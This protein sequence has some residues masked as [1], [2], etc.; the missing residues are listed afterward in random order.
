M[1]PVQM[2]QTNYL[3][4]FTSSGL[5]HTL[6]CTLTMSCYV[7]LDVL[8]NQCTPFVR[9]LSTPP[10]LV[11]REEAVPGFGLICLTCCTHEEIDT[12]MAEANNG[13][14]PVVLHMGRNYGPL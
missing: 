3:I 6:Q 14:M 9:S 11:M 4:Q 2:I 10:S 8:W 1:C 13:I 5:I 12:A 7:F